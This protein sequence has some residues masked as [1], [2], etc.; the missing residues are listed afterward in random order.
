[1]AKYDGSYPEVWNNALADGDFGITSKIF[2]DQLTLSGMPE[3][4][5]PSARTD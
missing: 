1:M 4:R 2:L 5:S 3:R